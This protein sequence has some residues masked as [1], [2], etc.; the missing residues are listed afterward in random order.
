[1]HFILRLFLILVSLRASLHAQVTFS[2]NDIDLGNVGSVYEIKGD[3]VVT[4]TGEE[5]VHLLRAKAENGVTVFTTKRTL[6]PGDTALL[7]ISFQP[8]NKG[9]FSK[10][11]TLFTSEEQ[12]EHKLS[13]SGEVEN[14]KHNDLTACYS[15]GS[16]RLIP[17]RTKEPVIV[18]GI[19][20]SNDSHGMGNI[21]R[22]RVT[23][24]APPQ[25][26]ALPSPPAPKIEDKGVLGSHVPNNIVLLV[27]ISSSMRDSLKL[28]LMKLELH[29]LIDAVRDV[30]SISLVT[31]NDSVKVR[32]KAVSGKEKQQLHTVVDGLKARGMTKGKKA[33]L[34]SQDL[35]QQHYIKG[36]NNIMFLASDGEFRFTPEDQKLWNERQ[37]KGKITISTV[38]FGDEKEALKT[39]KQ[40][41]AKGGGSFINI[42]KRKDARARLLEEV[43]L[44]SR[45]VSD[46]Q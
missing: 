33:I 26:P 39:L 5:K 6:Q 22:P 30:D 15:F 32:L 12:P 4:N 8:K 44:R 23:N 28:P 45:P 31:Y 34:F 24:S 42:S 36:G 17:V 43:E 2:Q 9:R 10:G 37:A 14:V 13:L 3:V 19:P 1:M 27:D 18:R 46:K 35:A 38:A 16:R 20:S 25:K 29:Q 11:I 7:V 21:P 40:I 41:A